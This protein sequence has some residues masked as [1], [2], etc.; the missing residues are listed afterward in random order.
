MKYCRF[1]TEDG[2]HC[3][4]IESVAGHEVIN[5][6]ASP[7]AEDPFCTEFHPT[8]THLPL[9]STKLLAPVTPSKVICV[10]RN[11]REHAR[12]FGNEPPTE[13]LIFLKPPSSV[14]GPEESV[15]Y[16]PISERV[17]FEGELAVVIGK[18]CRNA[19][20][21]EDVRAYIR[22][23]TCLNDV[24]AR[25]LQRKDGQWT[26]GKGFD[27]FCPVGPVISDEPDP[28][29]GVTVETRVNGERKQHGTTTDFI[30]P[31]DEIIRYCSQVMTLLP[32]DVIATGT[33]S[34][35]GP[36][37]PGDVMEI[38]IAGIGTLRNRVIG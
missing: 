36:V 18:R 10:G 14:I 7:H 17:D 31:L 3:G 13:L 15:V 35:V 21:D 20:A 24:T 29:K 9:E 5:Q 1:Q 8:M 34:G 33:P 23:Y 22:G 12:E 11:Y 38:S 2:I 19:R 28:W 25:D 16:P 30:F 4:I 26:R 32:G 27:T 37:K 6:I